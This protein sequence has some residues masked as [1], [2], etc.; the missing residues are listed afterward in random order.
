MHGLLGGALTQKADVDS[1]AAAPK[2]LSRTLCFSQEDVVPIELSSNEH[3][4][5]ANEQN[6]WCAPN[7]TAPSTVA[8][9]L[10]SVGI[11]K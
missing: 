4:R 10:T 1:K 6:G 9:H 3:F 5:R 7:T 8:N 2:L 11:D